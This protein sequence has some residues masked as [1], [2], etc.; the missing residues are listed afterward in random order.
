VSPRTARPADWISRV[1]A[2]LDAHGLPV[3]SVGIPGLVGTL[4]P[5]CNAAMCLTFANGGVTFD[6][7]DG[8]AERD[9][10]DRLKG[11]AS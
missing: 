11:R 10:N 5:L 3:E 6:C 7:T 4:C 2:R 8:C 9:V 1:L